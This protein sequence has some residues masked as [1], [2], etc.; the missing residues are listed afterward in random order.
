[1]DLIFEAFLNDIR[2]HSN[3][4]QSEEILKISSKCETVTYK[5]NETIF[6]STKVCRQLFFITDGIAASEYINEDKAVISR[7]FTPNTICSNIKSLAEEVVHTDRLLA[8]TDM[9][10]VLIPQD[11]FSKTYFVGTCNMGLYFRKKMMMALLADKDFISIKTLAGV[12][13]QLSFLQRN[14]PEIIL[15]VPWKYIA[16][17][18]GVSPSWLCRTLKKKSGTSQNRV[19]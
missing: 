2:F 12:E 3:N 18:M 1:M 17:F 5:K 9:T 19:A 13:Y 7:F 10:G 14:Y 15:N 4:L 6:S 8:V 16:S 11:M